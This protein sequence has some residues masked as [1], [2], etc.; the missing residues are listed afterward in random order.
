MYGSYCHLADRHSK[1]VTD[2]GFGGGLVIESVGAGKGLSDQQFDVAEKDGG[3]GT[4]PDE[5]DQAH[6]G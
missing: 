5:G 2:T 1:W 3:R 4:I 6:S